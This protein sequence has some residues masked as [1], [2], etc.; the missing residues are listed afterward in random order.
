MK[1]L[2]S[3]QKLI[4]H[5]KSIILQLKKNSLSGFSFQLPVFTILLSILGTI[6]ALLAAF[7]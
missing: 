2:C 6:Y 7:L 3:K 4:P 5:Y 1:S